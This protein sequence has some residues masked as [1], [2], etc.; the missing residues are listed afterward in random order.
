[1]ISQNYN[2]AKLNIDFL[3]VRQLEEL[4]TLRP[5]VDLSILY[6]VTFSLVFSSVYIF[7]NFSYWIYPIVIFFIAGRQGAFLQLIHEASHKLISKNVKINDWEN[8]KNIYK[9]IGILLVTSPIENCPFTVLEAKSYGIPTLSISNGGIKEIIR[10]N[11]D[12]IALNNNQEKKIKKSLLKIK[13]D[14]YYFNKKCLSERKKYDDKIN[15]KKLI[16][17]I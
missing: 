17:D 6:V 11:L 1:M 4:K 5:F 7:N 10:N 14:Y 16:N 15:Y 9:K 3:K 12:G 8:Q 13:K 2:K